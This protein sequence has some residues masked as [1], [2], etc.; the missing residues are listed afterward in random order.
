MAILKL[1]APTNGSRKLLNA[2]LSGEESEIVVQRIHDHLRELAAKMQ[3][4][5]VPIQKYIIYTV[6]FIKEEKNATLM[7][8]RN[9][10]RTRKI[11]PILKAC[12]RSRSLFE[13]WL[14]GR[15]SV[16]TMSCLLS[17]RGMESPLK[18]PPN[19]PTLLR[20]F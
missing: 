12:H 14:R 5:A 13:P 4:N 2:I 17:P 9:L 10:A 19:E 6:G 18:A 3:E 1:G 15:R 8:F 11:I 7:T 16:P 20:M